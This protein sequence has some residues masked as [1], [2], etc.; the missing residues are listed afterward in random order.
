MLSCVGKYLSCIVT[1]KP[2]Q[3]G[4]G[5]TGKVIEKRRS[6]LFVLNAQ[7]DF[8]TAPPATKYQQGGSTIGSVRPI[9][10]SLCVHF[11]PFLISFLKEAYFILV[12]GCLLVEG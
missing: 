9:V 12:L 1:T 5:G 4:F 2:S 11:I 6:N 7:D 10:A 3:R 8:P